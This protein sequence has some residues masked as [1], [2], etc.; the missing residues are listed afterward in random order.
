MSTALIT[1]GGSGLGFEAARHIATTRPGWRIVLGV[2]DM[3]AGAAAAERINPSSGRP[4]AQPLELDLASLASVRSF[5]A[6]VAS[7]DGPPL[8]VVIANAGIQV[9]GREGRTKDGFDETF[10][11]N[12]LGHFLLINLLVEHL[13]SPAR[14]IFVSSDTHDPAQRTGMPAPR[15]QDPEALARAD[16]GGVD[17]TAGRRRYTTSKLANVMTAYELDRRLRAAG[18]TDVG[19]FAFNPGLMPGTGLAR[20]YG[21]VARFAWRYVMP[22]LTLIRPNV[23]TPRRA[24]GDLAWLATDPSLD[25]VGGRYYDGRKDRRSSEESYDREKAAALWE[26]SAR[27]VGLPA[28]AT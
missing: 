27:L 26:A 22:A 19:A 16:E 1:G 5:S 2:R 9:I 21:R 25:G 12:H 11:V 8:R 4:V 18:R 23:H 13:G 28:A 3:E 7:L 20:D 10:G 17:P 6:A 15:W 24:G 14:V